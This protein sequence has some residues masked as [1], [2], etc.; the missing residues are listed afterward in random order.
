[1]RRVWFCNATPIL[2]NDIQVS[3]LLGRAKIVVEICP[4]IVSSG[5]SCVLDYLVRAL[6]V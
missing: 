4:G 2:W 6:S 5:G 1:M 3:F